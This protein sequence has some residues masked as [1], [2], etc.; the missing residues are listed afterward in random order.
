ML[1]ILGRESLRL[2]RTNIINGL[3]DNPDA[4]VV[5]DSHLVVSAG[6]MTFVFDLP[7]DESATSR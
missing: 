2:E 3:W 1:H 6:Q 5:I 7:T 4:M